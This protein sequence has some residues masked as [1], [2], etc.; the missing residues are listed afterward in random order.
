MA[1]KPKAS[2]PGV[3]AG[4]QRSLASFGMTRQKDVSSRA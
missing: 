2:I 4:A 1:K 3:G